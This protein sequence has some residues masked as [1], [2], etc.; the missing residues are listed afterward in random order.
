[1]VLLIYV[2]YWNCREIYFCLDYCSPIVISKIF[3][4]SFGNFLIVILTSFGFRK[5]N[6]ARSVLF[7]LSLFGY[8][9]IFTIFCLMLIG[10]NITIILLCVWH[11]LTGNSFSNWFSYKNWF[12]LITKRLRH[13]DRIKKMSFVFVLLIQFVLGYELQCKGFSI[14][15]GFWE[16][17]DIVLLLCLLLN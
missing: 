17:P 5:E 1:M 13:Y 6:L 2:C 15:T 7:N 8:L 14:S 10:L 9:S 4:L 16:L 11:Q 12:I 3:F